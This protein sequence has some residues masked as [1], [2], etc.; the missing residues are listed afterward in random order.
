MRSQRT[1]DPFRESTHTSDPEEALR[2]LD[3]RLSRP[4][5]ARPAR[6]RGR[7]INPMAPAPVTV[8]DLLALDL[9]RAEAEQTGPGAIGGLVYA[10]KHLERHLPAREVARPS[11]ATLNR[12]VAARRQDGVGNNTIRK[13]LVAYRRG[14]VLAR[15]DGRLVTP[16]A[17][18]PRLS[19]VD[20]RPGQSGTYRTPE[21]LRAWLAELQPEARACAV[22]ILLTGLRH[23][24]ADRLTP[25]MLRRE[26]GL[27]PYI[28]IP[29]HATK[30][31]RARRVSL[32]PLGVAAFLMAVP[33]TRSRRSAYKGAAARAGIVPYIHDRDLRHAFASITSSLGD[34]YSVHLAM[35]HGRTTASTYQH[36]DMKRLEA[37]PRC[38]EEKLG[39][40]TEWLTRVHLCTWRYQRGSR[41]TP[42]D[43][44][45]LC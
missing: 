16:I 25:A 37:L 29:A 31:K 1:V 35:G 15:D 12:Y 5:P 30:P 4:P 9:R 34:P 6:P 19:L 11:S 2:I 23:E 28:A 27:A 42:P 32:T 7:P 44:S 41:P 10:Y 33:L 14:L 24:E 43:A 22:L 21:Q 17:R 8:R 3:E 13:E 26:P 45:Q 40:T 38:V 20:T 18:I 36:Q 39:L